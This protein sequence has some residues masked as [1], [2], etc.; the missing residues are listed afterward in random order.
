MLVSH[1]R[2][3]LREVCDEFWL[4]ARGQVQPFDG[5]LDDYQKWLLDVSR[6]AAKGQPLPGPPKAQVVDAPRVVTKEAPRPAPPKV[7]A[8]AATLASAPAPKAA[9]EDRKNAKLSRVKHSDSTRPL[10]VEL[11]RIDER[12]AR[13]STEK[14]DV[15]ALLSRPAAS[16]DGYGELGRRLAHISA[17]VGVLE[18]RWLALHNDLEVLQTGG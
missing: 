15:E 6:A 13:L 3:L 9:P 1:D 2:A 8:K 12:M 18:E 7:Q 16:A 4:V 5:D 17:E 11:Q 14:L 10:R